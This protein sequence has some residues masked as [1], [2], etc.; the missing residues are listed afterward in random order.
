[1]KKDWRWI[2]FKDLTQLQTK[3]EKLIADLSKETVVS[4]TGFG[5]ILDALSVTG[6]F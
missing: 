6:I 1:M 4:I 5:F 2:L 3:V